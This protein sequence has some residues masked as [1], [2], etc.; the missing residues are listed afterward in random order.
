VAG[1]TLVSHTAL[2]HRRGVVLSAN[3]LIQAAGILLM[4]AVPAIWIAPLALL[5]VGIPAGA[6]GVAVSSYVQSTVPDEVRGR[7][8]AG[9][10]ALSSSLTPVAPAL[11]GALAAATSPRMGFIAI[12]ALFF[13]GGT[14]IAAHRGVWQVK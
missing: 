14:Y 12:G 8:F 4:L 3:F 10:M 6:T 13:L 2:K 5:L 11:L 7:V 1:L 9:V